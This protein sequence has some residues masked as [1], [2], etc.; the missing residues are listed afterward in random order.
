MHKFLLPSALEGTR[1]VL[2][3]QIQNLDV[4]SDTYKATWERELDLSWREA[5]PPNHLDDRG[6]ST[7]LKN[8]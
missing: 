3:A 7:N 5:G 2:K 8:C 4:A 1:K 6:D